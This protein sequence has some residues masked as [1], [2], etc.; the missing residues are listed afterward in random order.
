MTK[1]KKM[2]TRSESI[3]AEEKEALRQAKGTSIE[4]F[5]KVDPASVYVHPDATIHPYPALPVSEKQPG[6]FDALK[7]MICGR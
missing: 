3:A 7:K 1:H 2:M 5:R 4:F 6:C